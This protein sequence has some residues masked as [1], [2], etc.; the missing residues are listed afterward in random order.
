MPLLTVCCGGFYTVSAF[1]NQDSY[2]TGSR[3]DRIVLCLNTIEEPAAY[4]EKIVEEI[5]SWPE[6]IQFVVEKCLP[7]KYE[8]VCLDEEFKSRLNLFQMFFG[9]VGQVFLYEKCIQPERADLNAELASNMDSF[10]RLALGN[11]T[12]VQVDEIADRIYRTFEK[13]FAVPVKASLLP[14]TT[15]IASYISVRINGE[16]V[17]VK[18]LSKKLAQRAHL[19]KR[20]SLRI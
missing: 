12:E 18:Q 5:D 4:V 10:K 11:C 3:K 8:L 2:L 7:G 15:L 17:Y 19:N 9:S 13:F 6:T 1:Q 16:E 20:S 14:N